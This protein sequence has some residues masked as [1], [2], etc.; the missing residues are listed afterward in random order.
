MAKAALIMNP[1]AGNGQWADKLNDIQNKLETAYDS[2]EIYK[3]SKPGDGAAIVRSIG[4]SVDLLIGF[5]GDGTIYE[6]INALA[7]L[8]KRPVFAIIPGGTANDFSRAVNMS[9][10]PM[11]ALEQILKGQN[12]K[13]RCWPCRQPV[14][15]QFLGNRIDDTGF[16]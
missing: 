4:E 3:T 1:N 7:P 8:E 10:E 14:F 13:S 9:Q 5:G 15:S 2:A 12:R 11:E 16:R 6:L